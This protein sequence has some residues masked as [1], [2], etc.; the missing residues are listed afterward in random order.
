MYMHA[1]VCVSAD[2]RMMIQQ[3]RDTLLAE[4]MANNPSSSWIIWPPLTSPI[5]KVYNVIHSSFAYSYINMDKRTA[6]V[7]ERVE[8]EFVLRSN[9]ELNPICMQLSTR[10]RH[11]GG[12]LDFN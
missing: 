2:E 5:A 12:A 11:C 10:V 4:R 1:C 3:I 9:S 7:R 8:R 6:G